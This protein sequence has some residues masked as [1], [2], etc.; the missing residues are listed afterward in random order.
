MMETLLHSSLSARHLRTW[1]CLHV[2]LPCVRLVLQPTMM[3]LSVAGVVHR[4]HAGSFPNHNCRFTGD[5]RASYVARTMKLSL[6]D[7][8][9]QRSLHLSFFFS[10][11]SQFIQRPC[12]ACDTALDRLAASSC[13]RT[14][15]T[16]MVR[17]SVVDAF[18]QRGVT[19]PRPKPPL[20]CCTWPITSRWRRADLAC[21]TAVAGVHFLPVDRVGGAPLTT[22]SRESVRDISSLTLA[23]LNS[24][25]TLEIGSDKAPSL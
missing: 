23:H 17:R 25:T 24:S 22:G 12:L 16:T 9:A 13:R 3:C 21:R 2:Y 1:L 15:S 6:L 4:G 18:R 14:S 5:G 8:M 19:V 7:S 10:T 20:P 11:P